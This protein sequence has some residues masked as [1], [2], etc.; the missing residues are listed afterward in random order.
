MTQD[1]VELAR[2]L[3]GRLSTRRHPPHGWFCPEDPHHGELL[4]WRDGRFFCPHEGHGGNG[5][6]F[7]KDRDQWPQ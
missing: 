4:T 6:F 3:A 5:R 1:E 2:L 7:P